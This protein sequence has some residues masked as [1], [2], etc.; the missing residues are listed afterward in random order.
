MICKIY[1]PTLLRR[2]RVLFHIVHKPKACDTCRTCMGKV[3]KSSE[4]FIG[5]P[6]GEELCMFGVSV[7]GRKV[8]R[9]I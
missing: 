2:Y 5:S 7:D 8:L 3:G 9:C 4:V 1:I 6:E